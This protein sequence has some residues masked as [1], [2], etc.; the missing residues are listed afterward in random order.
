[1]PPPQEGSEAHARGL[2]LLGAIQT[3]FLPE[4][5]VPS[6]PAPR[7][8]PPR[9]ARA[10]SRRL[11][12]DRLIEEGVY[13]KGAS[14]EQ[15]KGFIDVYKSNLQMDY[16]PERPLDGTKVSIYKSKELQPDELRDEKA[17][18]IREELNLGWDRWISDPI[19]LNV[20]P[21]DHLTMLHTSNVMEL[22]QTINRSIESVHKEGV[23]QDDN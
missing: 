18:K 12:L 9:T 21:G 20:A 2:P 4:Q 1:M 6:A 14:L 8:Q 7:R 17:Q 22:A 10:R 19:T 3:T 11:L 16:L 15:L 23:D 13:P 5:G